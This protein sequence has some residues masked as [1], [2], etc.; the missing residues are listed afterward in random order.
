MP[1]VTILEPDHAPTAVVIVRNNFG[2]LHIYPASESAKVLA[3]LAGRVTLKPDDLLRAQA[4]GI[5]VVADAGPAEI[6]WLLDQMARAKGRA[7][8]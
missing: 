1:I 3:T 7:K 4:L 6:E 8:R 5:A 2:A